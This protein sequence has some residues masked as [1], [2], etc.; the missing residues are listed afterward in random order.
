MR[1]LLLLL[2]LLAHPL[3][4]ADESR[5]DPPLK[6]AYLG[7]GLEETPAGLRISRVEE[8]SAAAE[9]GLLPGDILLR[10]GK[11]DGLRS[12]NIR[13]LWQALSELSGGVLTKSLSFA[14]SK[15]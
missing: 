6:G 2:L 14:R 15:R 8:K 11:L 10:F 12:W 9:A 5:F 3:S 4:R 7:V 13:K 1:H